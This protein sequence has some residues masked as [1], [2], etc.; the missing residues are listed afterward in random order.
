[1]AAFITNSDLKAFMGY[2]SLEEDKADLATDSA[3]DLIRGATGQSFAQ[4]DGETV[5]L[6]G[7][8]TDALLLPQ[9][10]VW[11]VTAVAVDGEELEAED[12]NFTGAG[13]LLRLDADV[14]TLGRQMVEVT[15]SYGV[16]TVPAEIRALALT[17]A[18]RLYQQGTAVSA[19]VGASS[20]TFATDALSFTEGEKAIVRRYKLTR[21]DSLTTVAGS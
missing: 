2:P 8:G 13:L 18:T 10:P 6:D 9:L 19:T 1:M 5:V 4:V 16:E 3:C 14:W 12:Y 7:T 17:V 11:E 15:Y 21:Q 20:V